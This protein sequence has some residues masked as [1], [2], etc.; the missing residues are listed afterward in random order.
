MTDNQYENGGGPGGWHIRQGFYVY[1]SG[2]LIVPGDWLGLGFRKEELTKLVRIQVDL[3]NSVDQEW[4][5]DVKKSNARP[6]AS[7][8]EDLKRIGRLTIEK[9]VAVYQYRGKILG[10][11]NS[12]IFFYPWETGIH[13]SEYFYRINR[14][15]P[16]VKELIE[17]QGENGKKIQTLLRVIEETVPT[18]LIILKSSNNP[19][20][21]HKPFENAPKEE[22]KLVLTAMW[23]ALIR[24]G[25][26]PSEAAKRLLNTEPFS[27]Y[28]EYTV[29]FIELK[30]VR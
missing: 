15:Y 7:C 12:E 24:S 6:P 21:E 26:S 25:V 9:A 18:Q 22:L 28:P 19:D 3:P 4:N 17:N 27:D 8:R 23:D 16:L 2:R 1:R 20:I 5:I 13:N 10:R 14:E 29:S 11:D 30:S